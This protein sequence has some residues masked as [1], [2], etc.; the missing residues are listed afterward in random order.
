MLSP[1]PKLLVYKEYKQESIIFFRKFWVFLPKEKGK[2]PLIILIYKVLLESK[3]SAYIKLISDSWLSYLSGM[4]QSNNNTFVCFFIVRTDQLNALIFTVSSSQ[5]FNESYAKMLT[6]V[7]SR[8][9]PV[10]RENGRR[11]LH[12]TFCCNWP[13]LEIFSL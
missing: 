11:G 2:I 8:K 6:L 7:V 1:L 12:A 13:I 5:Y 9:I 10:N 4:N 3:S